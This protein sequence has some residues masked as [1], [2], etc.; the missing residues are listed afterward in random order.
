[1]A[2]SLSRDN[3]FNGFLALTD[4]GL[5]SLNT[6]VTMVLV[7]KLGDRGDVNLFALVFSIVS[8]FRVAQERA[9]AAP[10]V[11]FAHQPDRNR[12][13]YLGSSLVHQAGFGLTTGV[14]FVALALGFGAWDR[15]STGGPQGMTT[16]LW[17][18]AAAIPMMLLR[19]HLRAIS[20]T[21]FRYA[22][23][24]GLSATALMI[25][26]GGMVLLASAGW[27]TVPAVFALMGVAS[28][29]P[30]LVW[31]AS[32]VEP[33]RV[34][35]G[36]VFPDG[37]ESLA[38]SKWLVAARCFPSVASSL[39]PWIVLWLINE[40]AS[41]AFASCMTLANLSMMFIFGTN[42]FFQP[43]AVR[44]LHTEG[45]AG[46]CRVLFES[47][48]IF[49]VV[50][51]AL[52]LG[53]LVMGKW[54]LTIIYGEEFSAYHTV[55]AILGL[56]VLIVS[57]SIVAGNGMAALGNPRGLF[58]GEVAFAVVTVAL[59]VI[60]SAPLGLP[61]A[62]IA[63]CGGSLA[64]TGVATWAFWQSLAGDTEHGTVTSG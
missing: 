16:C 43:R 64:A 25:Q 54:L 44:A 15:L 61:G 20:C 40:D 3:L 37:K 26:V 38:Y 5:V 42:N 13:A 59:A 12:P 8:V 10:Y 17:V 47:A 30:S 6:F 36:Q 48:V 56:N 22:V 7:V 53:Y 45:R 18:A 51:T 58:W 62:A 27:F 23:A 60:L 1:M 33:F 29:I 57:Y 63:L 4:Q 2:R 49:T 11:V 41:G 19:E 28:L 39:L 9:L 34:D 14:I 32:R 46:L 52:C 55:V 31:W 24:C 50:L 35:R 21:H